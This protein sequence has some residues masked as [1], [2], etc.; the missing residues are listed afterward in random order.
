MGRV[1]HNLNSLTSCAAD[2]ML[3][4]SLHCSTITDGSQSI[5][6][7]FFYANHFT[8]QFLSV[9]INTNAHYVMATNTNTPFDIQRL[10]A[11]ADQRRKH[12]HQQ[13]NQFIDQLENPVSDRIFSTPKDKQHLRAFMAHR[14]T[15][16]DRHTRLIHKLQHYFDRECEDLSLR[17]ESGLIPRPKTAP[18]SDLWHGRDRMFEVRAQRKGSIESRELQQMIQQDNRRKQG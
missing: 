4:L 13:W 5:L 9:I 18:K 17:P 8:T 15:G 10:I 7:N 2:S 3:L 1:P 12:D 16:I 11:K 6:D 14:A